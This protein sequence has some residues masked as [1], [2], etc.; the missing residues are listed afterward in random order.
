MRIKPS[1][2]DVSKSSEL[3]GHAY[4]PTFKNQKLTDV[5]TQKLAQL[6]ATN[7]EE[8]VEK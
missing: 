3:N 1:L 4:V 7:I 5:L 6:I 8:K 2:S